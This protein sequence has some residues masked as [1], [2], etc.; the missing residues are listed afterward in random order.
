MPE[1]A[2]LDI[3][4][5]AVS[6][7]VRQVRQA[8]HYRLAVDV[9]KGPVLTVPG[10]GRWAEAEA[11]LAQHRDWLKARLKRTSPPISFIGGIQIPLRG[12]PHWIVSI[13]TLR[14]R[15]MSGEDGGA[16]VL[17][18][19]GGAT[20]LPRRLTDWLKAEA[21]ADL[22]A[23]VGR[24]ARTLGVEP[25]PVRVRDQSTRWGSCSEAGRLNF[26]WRLILAPPF[27]L[28]YV[29]A[30][31]VAHLLEMNHSPDFWAVLRRA[32]PELDHGR[33]WL[34]A[35]GKTLHAYGG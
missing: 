33:A 27:V 21:R 28:D 31:E 22:E 20:H 4:G 9:R 6:V 32:L 18:V 12:V 16:P 3:D 34:K 14:G 29:A 35:H 30:H 11:F 15:V 23:A 26:N 2:T 17:L 7:V 1:R 8:R 25:G 10:G 13:A 24:H 5:K 19:P